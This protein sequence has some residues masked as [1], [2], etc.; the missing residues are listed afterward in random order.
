MKNSDLFDV[1]E[2]TRKVP[3]SDSYGIVEETWYY[4]KSRFNSWKGISHP[5]R[6]DAFMMEYFMQEYS[7]K[8]F[9]TLKEI[10]NA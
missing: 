4:A 5:D 10:N 3:S 9:P 2:D 6:K 1:L 7:K 8:H